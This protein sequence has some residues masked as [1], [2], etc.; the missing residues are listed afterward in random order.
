MDNLNPSQPLGAISWRILLVVVSVDLECASPSFLSPGG[1]GPLQCQ[2]EHHVRR[3]KNP[4]LVS[5][6]TKMGQL[7]LIIHT[8]S[9]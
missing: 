5:C 6:I 3:K 9:N 4:L 1:G 7:F 8:I 2:V